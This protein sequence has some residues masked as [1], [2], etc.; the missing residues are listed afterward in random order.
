MWTL[1]SETHKLKAQVFLSSVTLSPSFLLYK[2][3]VVTAAL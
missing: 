1:E 3:R 2:Q